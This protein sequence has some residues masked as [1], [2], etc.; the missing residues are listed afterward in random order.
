MKNHFGLIEA[1]CRLMLFL[2]FFALFGNAYSAVT[3]VFHVPEGQTLTVDEIVAA[4]GYSFSDGDWI[5]KTG[6]GQLNA[7]TTYKNV[8]LNL[9]I[10]EGEL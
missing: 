9:L 1:S 6:G 3:N 4:N 5:S 2:S 7:V 10:K 8:Q